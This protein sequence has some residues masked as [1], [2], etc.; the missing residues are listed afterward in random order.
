M[1]GIT[2]VLLS[3]SI[4]VDVSHVPS[5]TRLLRILQ[6]LNSSQI[7]QLGTV[8]DVQYLKVFRILRTMRQVVNATMLSYLSEVL[9][10]PGTAVCH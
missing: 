2:R 1:V 8:F 6:S 7:N 3:Q 4:D 5:L 9:Y 10:L